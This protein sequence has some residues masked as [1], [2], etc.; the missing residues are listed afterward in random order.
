M[1]S[2]CWYDGTDNQTEP[3]WSSM[4]FTALPLHYNVW[5]I[6]IRLSSGETVNQLIQM[7]VLNVDS[8]FYEWT[9]Y[10][11]HTSIQGAF[12][13]FIF[14]IHIRSF[15]VDCFRFLLAPS[16]KVSPPVRKKKYTREY[17]EVTARADFFLAQ[18]VEYCNLTGAGF[19]RYL[20]R[21]DKTKVANGLFVLSDVMWFKLGFLLSW[22]FLERTLFQ[23]VSISI[24]S[25]CHVL[26]KVRKNISFQFCKTSLYWIVWKNHL[27]W[28]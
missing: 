18:T 14:A 5:M 23:K 20:K 15:P 12:R 27:V 2:K 4:R 9:E 28:V 13:D 16:A 22:S 19:P 25:S 21:F 24:C 10:P 17:K 11:L 26:T 3:E 6:A 1:M 7:D 8:K